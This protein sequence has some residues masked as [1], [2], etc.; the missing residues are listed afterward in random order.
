MV[1]KAQR[2][3]TQQNADEIGRIILRLEELEKKSCLNAQD[4]ESIRKDYELLKLSIMGNEAA[5]AIGLIKKMQSL[6]EQLE[7]SDKK[8]DFLIDQKKESDAQ[9]KLISKT[10]AIMASM[11]LVNVGAI[12]AVIKLIID[13]TSK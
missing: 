12:V 9:K 13:L 5:G 2:I 11:G 6:G 10:F 1:E 8:I 7:C 3:T 4:I